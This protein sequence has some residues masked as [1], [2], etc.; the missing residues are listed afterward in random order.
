MFRDTITPLG[1]REKISLFSRFLIDHLTED[2]KQGLI[3]K[4]CLTVSLRIIGDRLHM[5]NSVI[6]KQSLHIN[7]NEHS[8][9]MRK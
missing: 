8:S 7:V 1:E 2:T 9:I 3:D 5:I 4:F 6:I